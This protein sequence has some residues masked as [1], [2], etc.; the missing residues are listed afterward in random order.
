MLYLNDGEM[1]MERNDISYSIARMIIAEGIGPTTSSVDFY[2]YWTQKNQV[3][4]TDP[5]TASWALQLI[6]SLLATDRTV[7]S[8]FSND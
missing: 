3:R 7:L 6:K 1:L 4:I 2:N 5:E 8:G